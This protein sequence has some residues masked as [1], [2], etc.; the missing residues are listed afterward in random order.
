MFCFYPFCWSA[1]QAIGLIGIPENTTTSSLP[2]W[3]T[4]DEAIASPYRRSVRRTSR[5]TARRVS[6]RHAVA[7]GGYYGSP[8]G[9]YGAAAVVGTAIVVGSIVTTLPPACNTIIVNGITYHNC[10][11]TY[12]QPQGGQWIIVNAP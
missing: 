7:R 2:G 3:M 5:R 10:S 1:V 6:N 8:R 11:G 9:Y 12:Y 4:L